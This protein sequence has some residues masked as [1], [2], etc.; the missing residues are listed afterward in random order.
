MLFVLEFAAKFG[1]AFALVYGIP[2]LAYGFFS[3]L[4]ERSVILG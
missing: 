3:K 4:A 2:Y 1:I